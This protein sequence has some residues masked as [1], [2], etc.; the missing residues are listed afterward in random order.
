M[1]Q[2]EVGIEGLRTA[3]GRGAFTVPQF[4][5]EDQEEQSAG[6]VP[7]VRRVE[8]V[9]FEGKRRWSEH[10]GEAGFCQKAERQQGV[11]RLVGREKSADGTPAAAVAAQHLV[12]EGVL[13][14][15]G[16]VE[17]FTAIA[18]QP[19]KA[20]S[21]VRVHRGA[22]ASRKVLDEMRRKRSLQS[23]ELGQLLPGPFECFVNRGLRA[24]H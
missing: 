4:T 20:F 6:T 1:S 15:R 5:C 9:T 14:K 13:M 2:G 18:A 19:F 24:L 10:E 16:P 11:F 8:P 22:C 3:S 7:S 12:T 17:A 21:V 23:L